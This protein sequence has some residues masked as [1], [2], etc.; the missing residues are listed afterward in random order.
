MKTRFWLSPSLAASSL[1]VTPALPACWARR[2]M[3]AVNAP[4]FARRRV[5]G[6]AGSGRGAACRAGWGSAQRTWFKGGELP[7]EARNL[8]LELLPR[9]EEVGQAYQVSGP[10][11]R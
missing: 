8:G 7:V 1:T 5:A 10:H 9:L 2:R 4:R 6:R 3:A 11:L